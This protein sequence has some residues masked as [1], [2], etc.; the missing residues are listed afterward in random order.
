[1]YKCLVELVSG[2]ETRTPVY[3]FKT[4]RALPGQSKVLVNK[5]IIIFEGI[6]CMHDERIRKLF[7]LK[8]FIHCD[9]DIALARRIRRDINERGRDVTEVLKRYNRFVKKD[10]DKYVKPQMKYVDFTIPGGA[11]ND[12]AMDIIV[13]NLQN[14]LA[15]SQSKKSAILSTE[16]QLRDV[17][18][19]DPY[20]IASESR[21]QCPLVS[22]KHWI[23]TYLGITQA[24]DPDY[25]KSNMELIIKFLTDNT[26]KLISTDLNHKI[27]LPLGP[28]CTIHCNGRS[29]GQGSK[30]DQKPRFVL[31][32]ETVCTDAVAESMIQQYKTQKGVPVY[33]A[34]VFIEKE[35]MERLYKEIDLLKM[36]CLYPLYK[37]SLLKEIQLTCQGSSSLDQLSGVGNL[38]VS[39]KFGLGNK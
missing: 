25:V 35:A 28:D 11:N 12:I 3:C 34:F 5:E 22:Q 17:L 6:L 13:K 10:F 20:K 31:Y 1:M 36:V 39:E 18:C 15:G 27:T 24:D 4:H 9:P 33:A 38:I 30:T 32:I 16:D 26:L 21:V 37:F 29:T 14:R 19:M 7:D 8:I 2:E 23:H